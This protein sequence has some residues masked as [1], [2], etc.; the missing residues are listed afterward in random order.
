MRCVLRVSW[1]AR[2][3]STAC[4]GSSDRVP[5][6]PVESSPRRVEWHPWEEPPSGLYLADGTPAGLRIIEKSNWTG[7]GL[8]F[9][10]ADW[11][12]VKAREDFGR[13]GVYVLRGL[14]DDGQMRVYIGEADELRSRLTQHF[15]G[16]SSK[17]FWERAVAFTSKDENLNKAHVRFLESRLV[18]LGHEAKRAALENG[19]VPAA[20]SLSESDRAEAETFLEEMLVIYPLLGIDAFTPP[21][22]GAD[23]SEQLE[24]H[25]RG[26]AARGRDAAEGFIVYEGSTAA[27]NEV[28]SLHEYIRKVRANLRASGVLVMDGAHLKLVQDYTFSS[29]STAAATLLGRSANGRTAWKDAKGRSLREIQEAAAK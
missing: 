25:G 4:Q 11:P 9:A 16:P 29:P 13:P 6:A 18:A 26:I 28:A 14:G 19:N 21:P 24:L 27:A 2:Y 3:P 5:V 15:S 12:R 1:Q 10:R 23:P 7:R 20:P 17:D 8:D 22:K